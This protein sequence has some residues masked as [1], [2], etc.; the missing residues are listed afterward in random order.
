M[1]S[2]PKWIYG[3]RSR[4][5]PSRTGLDNLRSFYLRLSLPDKNKIVQIAPHRFCYGWVS[6]NERVKEQND[7]QTESK[8][9]PLSANSPYQLNAWSCFVMQTRFWMTAQEYPCPP[10]FSWV[11]A[12]CH[13]NL[14]SFIKQVTHFPDRPLQLSSNDGRSLAV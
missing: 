5:P 6:Q 7:T 4:F 2:V 1:Y 11:Y 14:C 13:F 12:L 3:R 10:I 8:F 9:S